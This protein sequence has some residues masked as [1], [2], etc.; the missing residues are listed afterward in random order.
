MPLKT[1]SNTP[2][3][4]YFYRE[5]GVI[6]L[7][8]F[9]TVGLFMSVFPE[10]LFNFGGVR[11]AGGLDT[12][13]FVG[14]MQ[15]YIDSHLQKGDIPLWNSLTYSG[16]PL[17][18]HPLAMLFYPPNLLRSLLFDV[19]TPIDTLV[20][21]HVLSLFHI[22]LLSL[23]MY[24]LARKESLKQTTSFVVSVS[25]G[26]SS[27]VLGSVTS[28]VHFLYSAAW[29]PAVLCCLAMSVDSVESRRRWG[30]LVFA[31]LLYGHQ[32][33]VG[34]PQ[35]T[36]Y[37]TFMYVVYVP[38]RTR[39]LRDD[40][41]TVRFYGSW[42]FMIAAFGVIGALL[43]SAHILPA[44]EL[45]SLS[46]R[47]PENYQYFEKSIGITSAT[48]WPLLRSDIDVFIKAPTLDSIRRIGA[49]FSFQMLTPNVGALIAV[50]AAFVSR[51]SG[52][53]STYLLFLYLLL[54]LNMGSPMPISYIL[55][56]VTGMTSSSFYGSIL[57]VV[58][59]GILAGLGIEAAGDSDHRSH[60]L[61]L[62]VLTLV[63]VMLITFLPEPNAHLDTWSFRW[64]LIPVLVLVCV[65]LAHRHRVFAYAIPALL[66]VESVACSFAIAEV[67]LD[68]V[69]YS[70]DR[71][72]LEAVPETH[73]GRGRTMK[74][75]FGNYHLWHN[76][77]AMNGYDPLPL[78]DTLR[79]LAN[80]G[81]EIFFARNRSMSRNVS[82]AAILK[83]PFWLVS[84]YVNGG[85]PGK[86]RLFPPAHVVFLK[87]RADVS[88]T[89]LELDEVPETTIYDPQVVR[90]FEFVDGGGMLT[91]PEV[92]LSTR[93]SA[94]RVE[95]INPKPVFLSMAFIGTKGGEWWAFKRVPMPEL[96]SNLSVVEIPAPDF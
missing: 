18:A 58:P 45:I 94:V 56:S 84:H 37:A 52:R 10:L 36:L 24:G 64:M 25:T 54:D 30:W 72:T 23:G 62:V 76:L 95:C 96:K 32:I 27:I 28:N 40:L 14:P 6:A 9:G 88:I 60:W 80:P 51:L 74:M 69:A 41:Q 89:R 68:F 13:W 65:V 19:Q 46:A 70:M 50:C 31:G 77:R 81:E 92:H 12:H 61:R 53:K 3:I 85:L 38:L 79:V 71:S 75:T 43:A 22:V 1:R 55:K 29:T 87:D 8:L 91:I 78:N 86:G 15:F 11:V 90:E 73:V 34:F 59:F 93:T 57:L 66:T 17:A 21:L 7:L 20:S 39:N 26:F 33:I 49:L 44:S 83:R 2:D 5:L 47:A 82:G 42:I 35:I 63:G 67:D 4:E 16:M 48:Y